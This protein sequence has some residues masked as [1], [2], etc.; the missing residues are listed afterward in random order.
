M[1]V[2]N[3]G[4]DKGAD[5]YRDSEADCMVGTTSNRFLSEQ[6]A[7]DFIRSR[8]LRVHD[9]SKRMNSLKYQMQS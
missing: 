3:R 1:N 9:Y 7:S 6:V 2:P 4:P 8:F 5:R